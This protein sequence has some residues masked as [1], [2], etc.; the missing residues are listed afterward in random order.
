MV[1]PP[2]SKEERASRRRYLLPLRGG[3]W[4]SEATPLEFDKQELTGASL[5]SPEFGGGGREVGTV[6]WG[7]SQAYLTGTRLGLNQPGPA[8]SAQMRR[9]EDRSLGHCYQKHRQSLTLF[10]VTDH[11]EEIRPWELEWSG[12]NSKSWGLRTKTG[13]HRSRLGGMR[14]AP[15]AAERMGCG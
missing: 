4:S 11:F 15:S 1:Q 6:Q 2:R 7:A 8:G 13:P 12:L 5:V 9:A 14:T 10:W 3:A